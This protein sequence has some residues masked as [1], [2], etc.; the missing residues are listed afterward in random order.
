MLKTD[1]NYIET[2]SSSKKWENWIRIQIKTRNCKLTNWR[3]IDLDSWT[4]IH[5]LRDLER[6]IKL[7]RV[8]SKTAKS[9]QLIRKG[10]A[11]S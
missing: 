5:L 6:V 11:K 3:I 9:K 7:K 1:W 4:L 8:D 10:K 2:D